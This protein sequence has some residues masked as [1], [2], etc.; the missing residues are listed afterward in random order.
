MPRIPFVD[1]FT[2]QPLPHGFDCPQGSGAV[3]CY[4]LFDGVTAMLLRLEAPGF[5]EIREK[6]DALE[7]NFC[8]NGRFECA[9]SP[10]DH[11]T[12]TPGDMALSTFD[13]THGTRAE[14]AS[15]W[16]IMRGS[17]ST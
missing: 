11:V 5:W 2:G 4:P 6:R 1:G 13:G 16:A 3:A 8:A 17:A 14:P 15:P 10:R 9:F 7:I 12:L